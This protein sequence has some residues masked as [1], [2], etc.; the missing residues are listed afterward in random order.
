MDQF[1][2]GHGFK[3]EIAQNKTMSSTFDENLSNDNLKSQSLQQLSTN[4]SNSPDISLGR[5]VNFFAKERIFF[6]Q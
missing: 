4:Q 3:S 2:V 6:I 1:M 5:K